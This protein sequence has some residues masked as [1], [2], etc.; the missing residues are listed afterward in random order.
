MTPGPT[1]TPG[2]AV[3]P[4]TGPADRPIGA[5]A[6]AGVLLGAAALAFLGT[7]VLTDDPDMFHHLALGRETARAGWPPSLEPFLYP[8]RGQ[9]TG[10]L[11]YWLGSLVIYASHAAL[12]E[13]GLSILPAA[14]G[15]LLAVVLLLDAT[16]RGGR[17]GA[18]S[19]A[20]AALPVALALETYRYRAVAR[21]EIFS[22]LLFALTLWA[23]RRLED[24]RP[25]A[26]LA[27]PL[28][29]VAWTNLHP[30][31]AVALVPLAAFV[32]AGAAQ[33]LLRRATGRTLPGTPSV[34]QLAIAAAVAAGVVAASFVKPA[35]G[36]PVLAA[37]R[38]AVSALGLDAG[39]PARDVAMATALQ[40]AGEL[41]GGGAA[42]W[43]TPAG[44]LM[45]LAAAAFL[46]R[47]RAVVPR[48]LLT[49][50]AFAALPFA[51]VRFAPFFAVAAAPVAARALSAFVAA[52]PARARG[53]PLRGAAAG[54]LAA[55][56]V[57][58]LPLGAQA[59]HV[60]FGAGLL[61]GAFPVR[62]ADYLEAAR[63]EGRLYNTFHMGGYL[64]WRRVGPPFW[65][66]RAGT[67]P[68]DA[69]GAL[70][71]PLDPVR[72]APLDRRWR[73]DALLLAY[74]DPGASPLAALGI[75]DPDPATWAL[76]AFDDAGLLYLRRD[77]RHAGLA[78]RDAFRVA[79]PA[80][81]VLA[82]PPDPAAAL[83]EWRR[84]VAEAPA[85]LRCRFFLGEIAL[86]A[87]L[88]AE[89]AA[90]VA[91]ALG[92]ARGPDRE[93]LASVAARAAQAL[94]QGGAAGR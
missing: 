34:R 76:V 89:A 6:L 37:I 52:L 27:L 68:E 21:T 83:A 15:A 69:A 72:F 24:G 20:C 71:G 12:G 43:T 10:P 16:P 8:L 18:T 36:N 79:S 31:T 81:P 25:R 67:L 66:G 42:L 90:A 61:P 33:A 87:G 78:A 4:A 80:S 60:R 57:A 86:A 50:A 92:W 14:I 48:E 75:F 41:R 3:T 94:R 30:A 58:S 59:P 17:T 9:T 35:G 63:F 85:C 19:L 49:V 84:S 44:A 51:A 29:A 53:W 91:P 32:V 45:A 40:A 26:L 13:A 47:P 54:L 11:P 39:D 73:F 46:L 70:A 1:V 62:G 5:R 55:A 77:G 7:L 88:P 65:D 38:F 82:P 64:E 23:I 28:V 56:A 22:V 93:V 74:P 2:P